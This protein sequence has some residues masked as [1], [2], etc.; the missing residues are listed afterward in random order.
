MVDFFFLTQARA[1]PLTTGSLRAQHPKAVKGEGDTEGDP[2]EPIT[3]S[4]TTTTVTNS[5]PV[6]EMTSRKTHAVNLTRGPPA[7]ADE[8][9]EWDQHLYYALRPMT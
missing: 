8:G 3:L 5:T 2:V 4:L 1:L 9:K 7:S 6:S